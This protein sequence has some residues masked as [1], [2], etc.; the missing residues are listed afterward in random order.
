[1][2]GW[3]ESTRAKWLA[4]KARGDFTQLDPLHDGDQRYYTAYR[5]REGRIF[6]DWHPTDRTSVREWGEDL[7]SFASRPAAWDKVMRRV[8]MAYGPES[9]ATHHIGYS[10]GGGFARFF[11]GRGEGSLQDRSLPAA[12]GS[13]DY[14]S[15][16]GSYA[17]RS[18]HSALQIIEDFTERQYHSAAPWLEFG[19]RPGNIDAPVS[20]RDAQGN[21]HTFMAAHGAATSGGAFRPGASHSRG[22][23]GN[24]TRS[25]TEEHGDLNTYNRVFQFYTY[26][27]EKRK[28]LEEYCRGLCVSLCRIQNGTVG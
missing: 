6:I 18:F 23:R 2:T 10:R 9:E 15:L 1:M 19:S 11:G 26:H 22:Y 4:A 25:I 13:T 28:I 3:Y 5:D 27:A 16:S 21:S 24:Q 8:Y 12:D 20:L 17:D 7:A 14:P